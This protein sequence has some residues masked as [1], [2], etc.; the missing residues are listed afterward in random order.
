MESYLCKNEAEELQLILEKNHDLIPGDQITPEDPRRW[1]NI[2]REMPVPDPSTG[3]DRWSIDF[4]FVDQSA[5]L[6]F[7]ECKRFNDSRARR[8]VIGQ[9]FDYAANGHHYWTQDV[10]KNLAE[11]TARARG[12]TLDEA[13]LNLVPDDDVA[14][15]FFGKTEY[16]LKQGQIR[17]VFFMEEAPVELKSIVEF[18]NNQMERSEVLLVEA[19]QFTHHDIKIVNP[20]LYGYTEQA[21]QIKTKV[22]ASRGQ[23][24]QWDYDSFFADASTKLQESSVN[25]IR[26]LFEKCKAHHADIGWGRGKFGGSFL[27]RWPQSEN[28]TVLTVFSHGR[29]ELYFGNLKGSQQ[30]ESFRDSWK[31]LIVEKVGLEVPE[32]Y[33][34]KFPTYAIGLWEPKLDLL[35]HAIDKLF[36]TASSTNA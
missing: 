10:L 22:S 26:K 4:L 6:T 11:A 16:N 18:L 34:K 30:L 17:L 21:R 28:K 9:M 1:L 36:E 13:L 24:K 27:I 3:A 8:E 5:I 15:D 31:D 20:M 19:K 33:Y 32:D 2:A 7:V 14:D 12:L 29:L 25:A 35:L 23:Q